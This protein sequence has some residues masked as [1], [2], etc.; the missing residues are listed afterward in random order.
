M[1][2]VI[3]FFV[4]ILTVFTGCK[5]W[6]G[7]MIVPA[8]DPI[9]PKLL[10]LDRKIEDISGQGINISSPYHS[11]FI[12]NDEAN[13]FTKEVESNLIDPY[14]DK[15]GTIVLRRNIIDAKYGMGSFIVSSLLFTIPNLFGLPFLVIRYKVAV[16]MR[17]MDR[18]NKLIGSYTAIGE[19][20][21]K[22]A[23]YYGYSLRNE[24]ANRKSYTDALNDAF[25]K[26]RPQIKSDVLKINA[27]LLDAGKQ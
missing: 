20:N 1:K 24:H 21:V 25:N 2:N 3:L 9:T 14:G 10:T 19:S 22:V 8:N 26:I 12:F 13:L 16:E 7:A 17:I 5:T 15:Y 6:N 11:T 27:K 4:I 23:Y 18:N